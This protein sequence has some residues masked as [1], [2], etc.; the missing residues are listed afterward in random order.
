M[1]WE[2]TE[3]TGS[4]LNL[5]NNSKQGARQCGCDDSEE[6]ENLNCVEDNNDLRMT[7]AMQSRL[8][9]EYLTS[10]WVFVSKMQQSGRAQ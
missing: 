5:G 8:N 10:G 4:K 6:R 1:I 7:K 2:T 9:F 3:A